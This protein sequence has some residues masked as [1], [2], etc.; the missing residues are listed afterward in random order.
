M[1][2]RKGQIVI[3]KFPFS[4]FSDAKKRPA[5]IISNDIIN[6]TGDYLMVQITSKIRKD[7]FSVLLDR[8]SFI[9]EKELPLRSCIRIHKIFLLNE[10]LVI[11]NYTQVTSKFLNFVTERIIDLI[12]CD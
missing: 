11:S 5:L 6:N 3:I 4:D 10:S 1:K 7:D 9:G 8:T 12:K 2:Y